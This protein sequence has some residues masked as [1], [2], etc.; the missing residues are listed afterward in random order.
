MIEFGG[1]EVE[2][3][4]LGAIW[5]PYADVAIRNGDVLLECRIATSA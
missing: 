3:P 1:E 5:L 4:K 2:D